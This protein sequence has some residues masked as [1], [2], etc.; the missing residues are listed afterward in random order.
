M[1]MAYQLADD[2]LNGALRGGATPHLWLHTGDPGED[3]D[4]NVAQTD[5]PADIVRKAL[6]FGDAPANHAVNDER[7]VL[8]TAAVE[9]S[10]AEIDDSQTITHFS[11]WD[12][13]SGGDPIFI[14]TITTPK[15]TGS[16]GVRVGIGDLEVAS[17]VYV[18]PA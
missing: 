11:I 3:G 14:S 16:D 15:T 17:E 6:T 18:K 12:A 2:T 8:N 13:L 7:F 4:A 5:V 10:G 9:W 1:T